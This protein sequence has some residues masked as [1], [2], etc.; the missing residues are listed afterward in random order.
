MNKMGILPAGHRLLVKPAED[1]E[2]FGGGLIAIPDSVKERFHMVQTKGELVAVGPTAWAAFGD[3]P[4]AKVGDT[5]MFAKYSGLVIK[6]LDGQQY[7]LINDD[8]L[9]AVVDPSISEKEE[10]RHDV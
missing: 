8:D 10:K 9:I 3:T 1:V 6:G 2:E 5:V 7:R 4:W